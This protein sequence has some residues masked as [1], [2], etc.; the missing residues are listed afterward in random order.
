MKKISFTILVYLVLFPSY[1]IAQKTAG[2]AKTPP[3]GWNI[4]NTFGT[5][6]SEKLIKDV[7]DIFVSK[8][9]Q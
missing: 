1:I 5:N 8:G 6:I 4:W 3:M 9:F 7:A 2:I